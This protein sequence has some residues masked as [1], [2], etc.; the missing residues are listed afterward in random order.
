MRAMLLEGPGGPLVAGELP[1]PTPGAGEIRLRVRA[2][3]V[4]RT[5]VHIVDGELGAPAYPLIPGH[6]IVGVVDALGPGARRFAPGT[7][8]GVAWLAGACGAC[9][10]CQS[11]REN[12]CDRAIFT[13]RSRPGGFAELAVVDERFAFALPGA[14]SDLEAAPLLCAGMIGAR[15]LRLAG[16]GERI[17]LYGFGASAHLVA[18]LARREGR[19]VHVFTRAGDAAAQDLARRLGAVWVGSSHERPPTALDCAIVFAPVGALVPAALGALDKGGI[20]VCAGI[21]MSDIPG[22]PY[23]LLWGER[24]VRSVANL[25]RADG[26]WLFERIAASPLEVTVAPYRFADA[27]RAVDDLRGGRVLGAAVL[28][29]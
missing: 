26:E 24:Q 10:F 27:G 6:Q 2:C 9:R 4:C 20:V 14:S 5:D 21:H 11:G 19:A 16:A 3:G 15:A 23:A 17:G 8:V 29:F 12:L 25:T 13:G 22:F 28:Q 18:Q 7:R 1:D